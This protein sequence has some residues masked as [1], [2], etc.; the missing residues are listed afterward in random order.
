MAKKPLKFDGSDGRY[1]AELIKNADID[2]E[3][4]PGLLADLQ[5]SDKSTLVAAINEINTNLGSKGEKLPWARWKY[6]GTID[7]SSASN[8][9]DEIGSATK[10][11]N[12]NIVVDP[13]T[14]HF[15]NNEV[16]SIIQVQ[17]ILTGIFNGS[18]VQS[19][20]V[21]FVLEKSLD[22]STW[23]EEADIAFGTFLDKDRVIL[24][25]GFICEC[26]TGQ[27]FRFKLTQDLGSPC[28][29]TA[30]VSNPGN[31]IISIQ[32]LEQ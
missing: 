2:A 30:G 14:G 28:S 7:M 4:K 8:V 25:G 21:R 26:N 29:I 16:L 3:C 19:T 27:Y 6:T 22:G 31:F 1:W 5:T 24:N 18:T 23:N 15:Q 12:A 32:M 10:I 11:G 13:A 17:A 20:D 9:I